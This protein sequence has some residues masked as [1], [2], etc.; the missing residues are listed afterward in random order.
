MK[1]KNPVIKLAKLIREDK[2]NQAKL[3][4]DEY[5]GSFAVNLF[6]KAQLRNANLGRIPFKAIGEPI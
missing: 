1:T 3:F 4:L 2:I 6:L 5:K